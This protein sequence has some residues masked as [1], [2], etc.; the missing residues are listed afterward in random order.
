MGQQVLIASNHYEVNKMIEKGWRVT[1][2]TANDNTGQF[3]F[4]LERN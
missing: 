1:S 2:V 4:I 3:C